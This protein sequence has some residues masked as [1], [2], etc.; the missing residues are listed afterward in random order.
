MHAH[1]W[2]VYAHALRKLG[3]LPTL[4]EWDTHLPPLA[5]LLDQA[6]AAGALLAA[7]QGR[8]L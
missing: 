7:M 6:Y 5:V 8:D 1:V 4:I 3:P 2:Q